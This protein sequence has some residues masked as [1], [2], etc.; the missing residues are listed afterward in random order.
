[1]VAAILP[2]VLVAL[3]SEDLRLK[4]Y[5][6][7]SPVLNIWTEP[8]EVKASP[9]STIDLI[10]FAET[11]GQLDMV[12]QVNFSFSIPQ[13]MKVVPAEIDYR[14]PFSG[15]VVLGEVKVKISELG[16]FRLDIVDNSIFSQLPN[17]KVNTKGTKIFSHN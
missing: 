10:V 9:G 11:V 16:E 5:A 4:S 13:G 17:L 15:R 1:V 14:K 7:Q 2:M 12:P 8:A 3:L 6:N